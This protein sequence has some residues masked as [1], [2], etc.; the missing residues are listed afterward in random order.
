MKKSRIF[1]S[2]V[3]NKFTDHFRASDLNAALKSDIIELT[4]LFAFIYESSK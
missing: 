3:Q 2:S 1:I 4:I